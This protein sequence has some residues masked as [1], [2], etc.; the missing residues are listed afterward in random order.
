MQSGT[1][2]LFDELLAGEQIVGASIRGYG[3]E[4]FT[5]R[6]VAAVVASGQAD[7]GVGLAAAAYLFKLDFIPLAQEVYYLAGR[8]GTENLAQVTALIEQFKQV[9]LTVKGYRSLNSATT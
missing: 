4:E 2:Q 6:A 8:R 5:H 7:V 1:R 9:A 3:D